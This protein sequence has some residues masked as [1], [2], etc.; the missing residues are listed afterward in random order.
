MGGISAESGDNVGT[1]YYFGDIQIFCDKYDYHIGKRSAAGN[2][3]WDCHKTL[4]EDGEAGVHRGQSRWRDECP[5]CGKKVVV[6]DFSKSAMGRELG[7]NRGRPKKKKGVTSCSSFSWA[8]PDNEETWERIEKFGVISEYRDKLTAKQ[9]KAILGECP[10]RY[11]DS[12]GQQF[13]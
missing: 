8:V 1:N 11:Y 3:C 4:C 5:E 2:Y 7:F 10:I 9:F 6:E 13:S 12:I